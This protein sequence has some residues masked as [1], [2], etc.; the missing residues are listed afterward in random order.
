VTADRP[1]GGDDAEP[2]PPPTDEDRV[3][4]PAYGETWTYEGLI[5]A[6]PGFSVAP[7]T[8]VALQIVGFEAAVLVLAAVYDLW[9]AAIVGT[10]AVLVAGSG[11]AITLRMGD[12]LRSL[13]VPAAYRRLAFGS[14]IEIVLSVL[15]YVGLVT[16]LFAAEPVGAE[17]PLLEEAL[18]TDAPLPAV[19][20][21]LLLAWDLVYRIGIAWWA[22][23]AAVWRSWRYDFEPDVAAAIA[24]ADLWPLAF[25]GLQLALVPIVWERPLLVGA[26]VGH[27]LAVTAAVALSVAL[28]R[29]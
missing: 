26:L 19:Y 24:R 12:R 29:R 17:T 9:D 23:I 10:V 1:Q 13:P 21:A 7:R 27:V 8:A 22:S 18:G 5:G 3:T 28:L 6:I 14:R 16:Y 20:L 4:L 11:S 25:A 15:A 2:E